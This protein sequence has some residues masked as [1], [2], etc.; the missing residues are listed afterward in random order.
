MHNQVTT[1]L[2]FSEYLSFFFFG[3]K[4]DKALCRLKKYRLQDLFA[5]TQRG[6]LDLHNSKRKLI[7]GINHGLTRL[8]TLN[9][10]SHQ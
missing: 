4:R 3:L 5:T 1:Y 9:Q 10:L 7:L 2:N 8:K 6:Y